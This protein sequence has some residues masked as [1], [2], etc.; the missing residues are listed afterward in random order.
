ME[1]RIIKRK[2]R[3]GQGF[4]PGNTSQLIGKDIKNRIK[5]M[6]KRN[7]EL[8]TYE[9][10]DFL[11]SNEDVSGGDLASNLGIVEL[12][13]ALHRVFDL[14]SDRIIWDIGCGNDVQT[15]LLDGEVDDCPVSIGLGGRGCSSISAA[16]GLAE[17]RDIKGGDNHVVAVICDDALAGGLTYE[18]LNNAGNRQTRMIVVV[19]DSGTSIS[20]GTGSVSQ[21]LSKLR[22]SQYYQ[23]AKHA[24]KDRMSKIPRVGESMVQ[25]A[26]RMRSL[27]RFAVARNALRGA[28]LQL[29]WPD[30]R[31]PSRRPDRV[32]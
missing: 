23:S 7:L 13:V 26:E 8:L 3:R 32:A 4:K 20:E 24:I 2:K 30:R 5:K 22:A 11:I 6:S 29:L 9:I 1:Y 27:M 10:R 21:Y 15:I 14:D 12:T 18:G 16:M 17:A 19:N 25:G 28:R 31:A